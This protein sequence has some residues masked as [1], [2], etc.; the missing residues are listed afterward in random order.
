MVYQ[1]IGKNTIWKKKIEID[2]TDLDELLTDLGSIHSQLKNTVFVINN[3]DYTKAFDVFK[4][5]I[6]KI[7]DLCYKMINYYKDDNFI[8]NPQQILDDL[9]VKYDDKVKYN[10]AEGKYYKDPD[11]IQDNFRLNIKKEFFDKINQ[12]PYS[13]PPILPVKCSRIY[14]DTAAHEYLNYI[15]D[16]YTTINN[17]NMGFDESKKPNYLY[18]YKPIP[19]GMSKCFKFETSVTI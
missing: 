14:I 1:T 3:S 2:N 10:L 13:I 18:L 12:L 4:L 19:D 7:I 11:Y 5:N 16:L 6:L 9:T 17:N 8:F 15:N